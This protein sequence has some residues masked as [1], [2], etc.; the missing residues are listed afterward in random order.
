MPG[1]KEIRKRKRAKLSYFRLP[2]SDLRPPI[3]DEPHSRRSALFVL[4]LLR[5][6]W[7]TIGTVGTI[8]K[9]R[10][11]R[12]P[13]T[14]SSPDRPTTLFKS[15]V[16]RAQLLPVGSLGLPRLPLVYHRNGGGHQQLLAAQLNQY[17]SSYHLT[18]WYVHRTWYFIIC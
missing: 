4:C 15:I 6:T 18:S 8:D 5:S 7:F 17:R 9:P 13:A 11:F 10:W 12:I 3:P 1:S 2:T 16:A 14:P